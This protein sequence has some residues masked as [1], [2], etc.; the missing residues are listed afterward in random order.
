MRIY[1]EAVNERKIKEAE[2]CE[3]GSGNGIETGV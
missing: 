2:V 3:W 1:T